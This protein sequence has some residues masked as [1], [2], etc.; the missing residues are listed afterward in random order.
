[1]IASPYLAQVNLLLKQTFEKFGALEDGLATRLSE[2]FHRATYQKNHILMRPG[3]SSRYI[4]LIESGSV[5]FFFVRDDNKEVNK[6]FATEGDIVAG[7]IAAETSWYGL[8]ALEELSVYQASLHEFQAIS[9]AEPALQTIVAGFFQWL[10]AK[11]SRREKQF[12]TED[13]RTRYNS[14]LNEYPGLSSRIAQYH[15]AAYLG[16]TDVALSRL[17]NK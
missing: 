12:L 6:S 2:I 10:A 7:D 1:M 14:F 11:K 15:I 16:I 5:R 8:Q 17:R 4:Y 9:R 13:A 3:D